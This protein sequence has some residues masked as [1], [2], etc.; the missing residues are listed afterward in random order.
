MKVLFLVC[1]LSA[2]VFQTDGFKVLGVLPIASS[3]HC[4]IGNSILKSLHQAGHEVT[5]INPFPQK[6]PLKNFRDIS[7]KD[8]LDKDKEG[9]KVLELGL[10][11][12]SYKHSSDFY[13]VR[14]NGFQVGNL[15]PLMSIPFLYKLGNDMVESHMIHPE[16]QKLMQSGEKFDVCIIEVFNV[17]ALLVRIA[18]CI[19]TKRI[20]LVFIFNLS[21]IS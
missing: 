3:S 10:L 9:E 19:L 7:T 15:H 8:I 1:S 13:A 17:D 11:E 6:K 12:I 16:I 18:K 2:L 14:I 5:A 21:G 20:S 4:A